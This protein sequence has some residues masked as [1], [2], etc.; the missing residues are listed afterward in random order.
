VPQGDMQ[1]SASRR[2][3]ARRSRSCRIRRSSRR[4]NGRPTTLMQRLRET[5]FLTRGL[6]ITLTDERAGGEQIEFHYEGGIRDFVHY[7]NEAKDP[8]HKHIVTSRGERT[9]RGRGRRCSGT[10]S[11]SSPSSR[12]PTTSTRTRVARISS[13]F[14]RCA[15][16]DAEQVRARQEPAEGEGGQSLRGRGRARRARGRHLREAAD[17]QF[18]GQTRRSSG[19]PWV[20]AS[21]EQTVNARLAEFLEEKPDRPKQIS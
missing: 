9:G 11:T 19:N 12:S 10:R 1:P 4:S 18:E 20:R 21:S 6:R 17:P 13:G 15:D 2:R 5:A 14:Q 8:V 16:A 7:V 3:P